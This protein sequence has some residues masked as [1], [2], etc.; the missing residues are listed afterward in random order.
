M[1]GGEGLR[2]WGVGRMGIIPIGVD[3]SGGGGGSGRRGGE[4]GGDMRRDRPD[5]AKQPDGGEAVR[6]AELA[7]DVLEMPVDGFGGDAEVAADV[8]GRPVLGGQ[9]QALTLSR[10]EA[11]EGVSD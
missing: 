2:P 9:L 11:E 8:L 4:D 5:R 1:P 10:G 3:G 6:N 7:D